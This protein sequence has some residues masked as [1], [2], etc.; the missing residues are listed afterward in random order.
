ML[1]AVTGL[2]REARIVENDYMLAVSGGGNRASLEQQ[3]EAALRRDVRGIVSFGVAGALAPE[4]RPGDC[5]IASAIVDGDR[6]F[7]CDATWL[8]AIAARLSEKIIATIAGSETIL[9][10]SNK[11]RALRLKT[12]AAAVDMESHVAAL[13][14]RAHNLP[15]IAVR[16]IS[17]AADRV[18][19]PAALSALKPDGTIDVLGV[20]RSLI[21]QP[22]QIP[23]LMRTASESER[24]FAAL[25]RCFDLLGPRLAFPDLG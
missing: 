10:D 4:L 20:A 21:A 7:P 17:D 16:T 12:G 11:K 22:T 14:A 25:L 24:A 13:A 2:R 8:Q 5:V 9:G 6:T 19:P 18:L 3:I 15:F 1:L 23:A